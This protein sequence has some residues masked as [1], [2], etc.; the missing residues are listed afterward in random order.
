MDISYEK[1]IGKSYVKLKRS[2]EESEK[3]REQYEN[4]T[5]ENFELKIILSNLFEDAIEIKQINDLDEEIYLY[6]ITNMISLYEFA[7]TKAVNSDVITLLITSLI[8]F[9]SKINDYMISESLLT[10][11]PE[12][13]FINESMDR[14]AFI[15]YPDNICESKLQF[16]KLADFLINVVDYSD[17]VAVNMAYDFFDMIYRDEY[18]FES[19][20]RKEHNNIEKNVLEETGET[21]SNATQLICDDALGT[22]EDHDEDNDERKYV[23]SF[24]IVA[25]TCSIIAIMILILRFYA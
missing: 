17:K 15:L 20:I 6:D 13:I 7:K 12:L 4:N 19:I 25:L 22:Y 5:C 1:L 16:C 23:F 24:F 2:F 10:T 8:D 14:I 3:A 21:E 11:L 18:S 9:A